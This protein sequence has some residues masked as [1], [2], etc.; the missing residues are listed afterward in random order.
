MTSFNKVVIVGNVTR[1]IEVRHIPSGTA[2]A[3]V[4][5]AINSTWTDKQSNEKKEEVTFVE[6]TLWGRTAEL[7]AEYL[8]KGIPVLFEGSLKQ[9]NWEDKETGAK[10]SKIKVVVENMQFLGEKGSGGGGGQ[11]GTQQQNSGG[12]DYSEYD[13]TNDRGGKRGGGYRGGYRR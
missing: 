10:R 1:D 2:V 5:I 9:E 12:R 13:Q 3:D 8:K 7:A 11:R 4:S 6:C